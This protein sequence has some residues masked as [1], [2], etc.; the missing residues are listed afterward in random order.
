MWFETFHCGNEKVSTMDEV[1]AGVEV[2]GVDLGRSEGV[3]GTCFGQQ[4]EEGE[5]EK[6]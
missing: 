6:E 1:F 5:S 3:V 2:S 4:N